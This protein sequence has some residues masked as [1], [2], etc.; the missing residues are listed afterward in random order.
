MPRARAS[1]SAISHRCHSS[2]CGEK[3]LGR[4]RQRLLDVRRNARATQT[5]TSRGIDAEFRDELFLSAIVLLLE[6]ARLSRRSDASALCPPSPRP[7]AAGY[8]PMTANS[9]SWTS[10]VG[11]LAGR[12]SPG[13]ANVAIPGERGAVTGDAQRLR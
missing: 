9:L 13:C 2:R 5:W 10:L 12:T 3:R 1:A 7:Q 11:S 8:R 4:R 6:K